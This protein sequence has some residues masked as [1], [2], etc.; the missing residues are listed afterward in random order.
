MDADVTG[1]DV[2]PNVPLTLDGKHGGPPL[3]GVVGVSG[4]VGVELLV[5]DSDVVDMK[6][7]LIFE[8]L[9][10]RSNGI[11]ADNSSLLSMSFLTSKAKSTILVMTR[12]GYDVA[13]KI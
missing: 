12:I 7:R 3:V 4:G 9:F 5:V 6:A 11:T 8:A 10:S 1:V 2:L 13:E